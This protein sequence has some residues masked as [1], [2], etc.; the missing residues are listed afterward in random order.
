MYSGEL[1]DIQDN[2]IDRITSILDTVYDVHVT[3]KSLTNV[4]P[5]MA[6]KSDP[7]LNEL[8]LALERIQRGEYGN[9]IFCKR[10][11]ATAILKELPTAHFCHECAERLRTRIQKRQ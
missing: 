6:F 1:K 5:T 11:I 7:H 4:L 10:P 8:R 2:I 3:D 9:C